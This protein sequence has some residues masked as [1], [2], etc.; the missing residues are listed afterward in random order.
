MI[1]LEDKETIIKEL[2]FDIKKSLYSI[3]SGYAEGGKYAGLNEDEF[4][5]CL[6]RTVRKYCFTE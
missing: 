5:G 1:P 2:E 6:Y 4:M 3:M